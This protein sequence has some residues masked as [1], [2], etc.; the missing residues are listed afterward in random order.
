MKYMLLIYTNHE[1]WESLTEAEG[2]E[3][4]AAY[5]TFTEGII[6]TGEFVSGAPLDGPETATTV[7]VRNGARSTTDGPFVETKEH[8]AGYYIVDCAT[9]DRA[10][11]LAAELPDA[12]F[13]GVEVR[14]VGDM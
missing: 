10:L 2:A 11:D 12:K 6:G 1:N 8:L 5:G 13:A 7:R 14:P 4:S 3:M 9:L